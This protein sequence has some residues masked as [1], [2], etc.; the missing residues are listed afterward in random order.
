VELMGGQIGIDSIEGKGS[1][2]WFTV[3][4]PQGD[5][6]AE[7]PRAEAAEGPATQRQLRILVAE[8]NQVNQM[9]IGMMLRQIGHQVDMAN[10]GIEACEQV[11]KAPYDIVL[12]DVQMPEMDGM[13]ATRTI[14]HLPGQVARIPIVALT[15]NA[16]EG[17]REAYLAAG[18]D[19]YAAK[20][21]ALPQLV[22]AMNRA[23]GGTSDAQ[24]SGTPGAPPA[25]PGGLSAGAK[26]GLGNL[27]SSLKKLN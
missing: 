13:T 24:P 19:D 17:D 3:S 5:P 12:M 10:N 22:A 7:V 27:L 15:A 26:A 11:Q 9:V 2:F 20:P 6:V 16:M 4:L 21:I 18:M 23:L 25:A 8:D 14:R 1:T